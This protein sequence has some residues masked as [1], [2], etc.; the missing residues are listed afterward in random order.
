MQTPPRTPFATALSALLKPDD[1]LLS[2]LARARAQPC[3]TGL[4]LLDLLHGGQGLRAGDVVELCGDAGAGK[5]ALL[6]HATARLLAATEPLREG[7]LGGALRGG[8][9][10]ALFSL[11]GRFSAH[12]LALTVAGALAREAE[13]EAGGGSGGGGSVRPLGSRLRSALARVDVHFYA[14]QGTGAL[15]EALEALAA[16]AAPPLALLALDGMGAAWHWGCKLYGGSRALEELQGRLGGALER[17]RAHTRCRVL[18]ARPALFGRVDPALRAPAGAAASPAAALAAAGALAECAAEEAAGL[19]GRRRPTLQASM[20]ALT[21]PALVGEG[22]LVSAAGEP[23]TGALG[24]LVT[25]RVVLTRLRGAG[26][27]QGGGGEELAAA[28]AAAA[29]AACASASAS[30][31]VAVEVGGSSS[32]SSSSSALRRHPSDTAWL[33]S[34]DGSAGSSSSDS[35][36]GKTEAT[37]HAVLV[38][39]RMSTPEGVKESILALCS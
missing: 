35:G 8:A 38:A 13:C 15:L 28:A 1:T 14:A 32:S 18:W 36:S 3:P 33:D 6:L 39:A 34:L 29:A 27:Q 2:L 31:A 30:L 5:S 26:G 21:L 7:S 24:A 4:P 37:F 9:R 11:D 25:H 23:L 22:T 16:P 17:V 20:P 10:V 19:R 12:A